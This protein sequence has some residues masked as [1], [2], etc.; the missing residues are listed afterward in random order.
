MELISQAST[1]QIV[2]EGIEKASKSIK[3]G[4]PLRLS[5][6]ETGLFDD[7]F[8][9]MVKIGEDTGRLDDLLQSIVRFYDIDAMISLIEPTMIMI[10]GGIIGVI[11]IAPYTCQ[12]LRLV[13]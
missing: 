2:K 1:M 9:S 7:L 8:I 11:L 4:K 6:K 12:Y 3:E 10:I 13:R 5:L